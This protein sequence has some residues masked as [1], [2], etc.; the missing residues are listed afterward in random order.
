MKRIL[1]IAL[2][3]ATLMACNQTEKKAS[4]T[5]DST[6]KDTLTAKSAVVLKDEKIN[7]I[8]TQY[9]GIK[10]A[11]VQSD[12]IAAQ[13]SAALLQTSLISY[14]GCESTAVTASKIADSKNLASQR[15]DFTAL[16]SDLIALFKHADVTEGTI[17]VQHCPMANKGDG[18]DWL[19]TEKDIKNPYY[20]AE[21]LTC[22]RV[23]EEIKTK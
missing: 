18:G 14:K 10:N 13:Q 6:T 23:V 16:S 15:K 3:A 4:E 21:M 11:L 2:V 1:G 22:G 5:K 17:Y 20:G 12:S 9:E 19:S 8:F 7:T